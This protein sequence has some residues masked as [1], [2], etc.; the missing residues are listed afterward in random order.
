MA[1]AFSDRDVLH[2]LHAFHGPQLFAAHFGQLQEDR[3]ER[4]SRRRKLPTVGKRTFA[5][6]DHWHT[7]PDYSKATLKPDDCPRPPRATLRD[8]ICVLGSHNIEAREWSV[9]G[10]G[11]TL[12]DMDRERVQRLVSSC[13]PPYI[14]YLLQLDNRA[15]LAGGAVFDLCTLARRGDDYFASQSRLAQLRRDVMATTLAFLHCAPLAHRLPKDAHLFAHAHDIVRLARGAGGGLTCGDFDIFYV[16]WPDVYGQFLQ[17]VLP[18]VFAFRDPKFL[19]VDADD[20]E[21]EAT[22]AARRDKRPVKGYI[23]R[24]GR[25]VTLRLVTEDK[26]LQIVLADSK[27]VRLD[28]VGGSFRRLQQQLESFDIAACKL[29]LRN[30][31]STR[32]PMRVDD[33]AWFAGSPYDDTR[34]YSAVGEFCPGGMGTDVFRSYQQLA[35]QRPSAPGDDDDGAAAAPA[36]DDLLLELVMTP[37]SLWWAQTDESK[38]TAGDWDSLFGDFGM[39]RESYPRYASTMQRIVKYAKRGVRH[40]LQT[41]PKYSGESTD[42]ADES[43]G[44]DSDAGPRP[45]AQAAPSEPNARVPDAQPSAF[46]PPAVPQALVATFQEACAPRTEEPGDEADDGL[47]P[48]EKIV[49]RAHAA[50]Q[51]I[52]EATEQR[53]RFVEDPTGESVPEDLQSYYDDWCEAFEAEGSWD[54]EGLQHEVANKL[55][56]RVTGLSNGAAREDRPR[57]WQEPEASGEYFDTWEFKTG[58]IWEFKDYLSAPKLP[59]PNIMSELAAKVN[60]SGRGSGPAFLFDDMS[61]NKAAVIRDARDLQTF[62]KIVPDGSHHDFAA[63]NRLATV[64]FPSDSEIRGAVK[65][66]LDTVGVGDPNPIRTLVQRLTLKY[67]VDFR[68][69]EEELARMLRTLIDEEVD[70]LPPADVLR[71]AVKEIHDS[72]GSAKLTMPV[73]MDRLS[74]KFN[75]NFRFETEALEVML[76]AVVTAEKQKKSE[77]AKVQEAALF[78]LD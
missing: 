53:A 23:C 5:F 30:A 56:G 15:V 17:R 74:A 59:S 78:A 75:L 4:R 61:T 7:H 66:F 47:V 11:D 52:D 2:A 60:A 31:R 62:L 40:I 57:G 50:I 36:A 24:H 10:R 35:P 77:K 16:G 27:A 6:P 37:D 14:R 26:P 39:K 44:S 28:E 55:C 68:P 34:A 3:G 38:V 72:V 9:T 20:E 49:A 32:P 33:K 65:A 12:F 21:D 43:Y 51:A 73:L 63:A 8:T 18:S 42:D 67:N 29:G 54:D 13:V 69:K 41:S 19:I 46:K 58:P 22:R 1:H 48:Q 70:A 25:V 71:P 45:A 76:D 64:N